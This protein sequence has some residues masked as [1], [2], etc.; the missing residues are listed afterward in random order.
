MP[1]VIGQKS[2]FSPPYEPTSLATALDQEV[3]PD[4]KSHQA[5]THTIQSKP[6]KSPP[7]ETY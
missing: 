1:D 7:F 3:I 6:Q 5:K 4:V 2:T